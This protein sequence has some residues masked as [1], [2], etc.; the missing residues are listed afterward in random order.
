VF[1]RFALITRDGETLGPVAFARSDFKP[2][3]LIPQGRGASLRVVN[4]IEAESEDEYPLL[5]VEPVE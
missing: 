3:D 5:V 1:R 2:G 4:V